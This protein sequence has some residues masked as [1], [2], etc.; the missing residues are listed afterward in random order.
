MVSLI[1]I[2][3]PLSSYLT[4]HELIALRRVSREFLDS[5]HLTTVT[6]IVKK[7]VFSDF[8]Q[9]FWN[10]PCK[11]E[12]CVGKY[13]SIYFHPTEDHPLKGLFVMFDIR[14]N[15]FAVFSTREKLISARDYV[16]SLSK[17]GIVQKTVRG[18]QNIQCQ[19]HHLIVIGVF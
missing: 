11:D 18:I 19:K 7:K 8:P 14:N 9:K 16:T 4:L 12:A 17:N 6:N 3:Q 5:S 2:I 10:R 1:H 15:L 13:E